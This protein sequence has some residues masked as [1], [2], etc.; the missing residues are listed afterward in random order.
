MSDYYIYLYSP[1]DF[2]TPLTAETSSGNYGGTLPVTVTLKAGATPVLVRITD[3]EAMFNEVDKTQA[4]AAPVTLNGQTWPAGATINP[5][6]NLYNPGSSLQIVTVHFGGDGYF[7]GPI[8]AVA[9]TEPLVPGQ[10][11]TFTKQIT[12]EQAPIPYIN[13][14]CFAAGTRIATPQGA[15]TVEDLQPGDLVQTL[16][17]GLQ[18]LREVLSTTVPAEGRFA[19]VVIAAGTC[20]NEHDLM[21]SPQHRMLFTGARAEL[22]FGESEV[23]VAACHL[24]EAGLA[25]RR[26][27]GHVTYYH[28]VFE[29]HEIIFSEGVPS[30][31]F[32]PGQDADLP[33]D[34]VE[35]FRALFPAR[36]E[37]ARLCLRAHEA[38]LLLAA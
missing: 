19:P 23:L 38:A 29:R 31:S 21:L 1:A 26:P 35:E 27:G 10:A 11:Y 34:T 14:W 36:V 3:N 9:V 22:L 15:I 4:L 6:Y 12:S 13:L 8:H 18:P 37:P 17:N 16:D 32:L 7:A 2:V 28:L 25:H 20:G 33:D 24:I 5:A 30:E